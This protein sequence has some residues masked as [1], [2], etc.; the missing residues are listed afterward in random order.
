MS[1]LKNSPK[2]TKKSKKEEQEKTVNQLRGYWTDFAKRQKQEDR[3]PEY[4]CHRDAQINSA[5]QQVNCSARAT[6]ASRHN[7]VDVSCVML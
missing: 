3:K 5:T 1:S 4:F 6:T 2:I 7:N